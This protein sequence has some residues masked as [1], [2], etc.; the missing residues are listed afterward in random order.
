VSQTQKSRPGDHSGAA[1]GVSTTA[2]NTPQARLAAALAY[3]EQN[4][5]PVFPC[6]P[7]EKVPATAR[8]C[9]DA[10][11][12]PVRIREW[13]T[14]MPEANVAIGCGAPGPDVLDIDTKHGAP[15]LESLARLVRAGHARGSHSLVRTPSGGLHLYFMG[16]EQCNGTLAKSGVD[17]RSRGGYVLAPPSVV[18][19]TPYLLEA[20]NAVR[21]TVDWQSIR[22]F[23]QPP[24]PMMRRP[25]PGRQGDLESLAAWVAG[26]PEGGRNTGLFWAACTALEGG[27]TDLTPLTAAGV[28]SGLPEAEVLRTVQ[29][30]QRKI[31][32]VR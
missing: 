20:T 30:A 32:G 29:S 28:A 4:H 1:H 26:R 12:D 9:R 18:D 6:R 27:H 19:G 7:G 8:G 5:W 13:W 16:T 24:R 23:L 10:S 3:A 11:T 2:E 22:S 14:R 15:G 25:Q 17:F 21:E 31:G